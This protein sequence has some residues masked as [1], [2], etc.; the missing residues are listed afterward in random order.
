MNA[1]LPRRI[2]PFYGDEIVAVQQGD[3]ADISPTVSTTLGGVNRAYFVSST[4]WKRDLI[5]GARL[6]FYTLSIITQFY[7]YCG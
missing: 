7:T 5:D 6:Y 1:P 2:V 4:V 3:G